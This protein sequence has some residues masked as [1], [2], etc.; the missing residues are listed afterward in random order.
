MTMRGYTLEN[1]AIVAHGEIK[2]SED[3]T[4]L[5]SL[6]DKFDKAREGLGLLIGTVEDFA[7]IYDNMEDFKIEFT[8]DGVDVEISVVGSKMVTEYL[9]A[10]YADEG[11]Y[12]GYYNAL[13]AAKKEKEEEGK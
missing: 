8:E 6:M 1:G 11:K 9:L 3:F 5:M 2:A 12:N 4:M 10:K 13:L 7:N